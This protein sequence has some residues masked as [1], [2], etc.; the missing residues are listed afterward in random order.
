[1]FCHWIEDE[2]LVERALP[3]EHFRL[4][5]DDDQQ[6]RARLAIQERIGRLHLPQSAS[7]EAFG[8]MV[9]GIR[10]HFDVMMLCD[11]PMWRFRE[12]LEL[13]RLMDL[14]ELP[15]VRM[16]MSDK[17]PVWMQGMD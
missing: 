7:E 14:S 4:S 15:L 1:D 8:F 6:R 2:N 9:K 12:L 11:V 17:P 13:I 16:S 3:C 10:A 5:L